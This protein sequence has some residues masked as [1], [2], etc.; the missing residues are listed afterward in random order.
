MLTCFFHTIAWFGVHRRYEMG[1]K[2][3]SIWGLLIFVAPA[4]QTGQHLWMQRH[5][6]HL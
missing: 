4:T 2:R 6:K 5:L 3:Q 1:G